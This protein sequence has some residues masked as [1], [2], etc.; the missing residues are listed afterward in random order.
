M[1]SGIEELFVNGT[2]VPQ[3]HVPSLRLVSDIFIIPGVTKTV[4][5]SFDPAQRSLTVTPQVNGAELL[6]D[7]RVACS[8][9]DL[10]PAQACAVLERVASKVS[11]ANARQDARAEA[12]ELRL[13]G[14]VLDRL[15]L[16]T[17]GD[18]RHDWDDLKARPEC[19]V[20]FTKK[21]RH[22]PFFVK[23]L[24]YFALKADVAALLASL[25]RSFSR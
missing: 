3:D 19:A 23:A 17:E 22:A 5:I 25:P 2:Y 16:G 24:A 4:Q 10:G 7:T 6:K 9:D 1:V 15:H 13:Y 8:L 18:Q 11:E 12:D 14:R 21:N 20:L